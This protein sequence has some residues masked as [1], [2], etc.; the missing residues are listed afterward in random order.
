MKKLFFVAALCAAFQF[1]PAA[2]ANAANT[3][4]NISIVEDYKP[5]KRYANMKGAM[6]VTLNKDMLKLAAQSGG[7]NIPGASKKLLDI[8]E[9]MT[10]VINEPSSTNTADFLK[11]FNADISELSA[12]KTYETVGKFAQE[13]Q[14]CYIFMLPKGSG[15]SEILMYV[16][17]NEGNIIVQMLGNYSKQDLLD[18]A[19]S[20]DKK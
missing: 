11:A 10:M 18:I 3:E 19:K 8:T 16:K 20:I 1:T 17:S 14:S 6:S 2:A 13:G 5:I 7:A 9:S 15:A 12:S 4:G